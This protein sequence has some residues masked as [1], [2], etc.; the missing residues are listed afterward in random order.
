[1]RTKDKRVDFVESRYKRSSTPKDFLGRRSGKIVT[2]EGNNKRE[3]PNCVLSINTELI[4]KGPKF[5]SVGSS[6][7]VWH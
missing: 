3:A 1:M 5:P 4:L 7:A 2:S 6:P